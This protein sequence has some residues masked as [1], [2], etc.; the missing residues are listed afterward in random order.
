[1]NTPGSGRVFAKWTGLI[2][3]LM[4][5]AVILSLLICLMIMATSWAID[6]VVLRSLAD[7]LGTEP[8]K[9]ALVAHV[10]ELLEDLK[11]SDREDVHHRL[12]EVGK[13]SYLRPFQ[14][15]NGES[16]EEL[17]W[18]LAELPLGLGIRAGWTVRYDSNDRLIDASYI[19]S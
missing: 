10:T 12:N 11:G 17:V 19:D 8:S 6:A 16:V 1:M 14:Y 7:Q 4:A 9:A 15:S 3:G 2:V 18:V 13:F 5:L